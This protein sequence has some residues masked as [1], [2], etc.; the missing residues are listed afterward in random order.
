MYVYKL[1]VLMHM[2]IIRQWLLC[3]F[4]FTSAVIKLYFSSLDNEDS[5][6]NES[7]E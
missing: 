5:T 2:K 4:L 1:K 6:E 3:T 7:G